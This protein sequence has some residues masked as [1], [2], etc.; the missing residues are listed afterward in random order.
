MLEDIEIVYQACLLFFKH[1]DYDEMLVN[2]ICHKCEHDQQF[3]DQLIEL[4]S[5]Y[6]AQPVKP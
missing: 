3:L 2:T 1:N 4:V 5:A 6:A